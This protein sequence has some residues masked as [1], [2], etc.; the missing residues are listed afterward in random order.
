MIRRIPIPLVAGGISDNAADQGGMDSAE[1]LVVRNAF[2]QHP[3]TVSV[4]RGSANGDAMQ[5]DQGTPADVTSVPFLDYWQDQQV[6]LAVTHST[7]QN[8]H[9][10]HRLNTDATTP[11]RFALPA[12]YD[13]AAPVLITGAGWFNVEY[14]LADI[15]QAKGLVKFNGTTASLISLD[16]GGGAGVLKPKKVFVHRNHLCILGYGD[17]VTEIAPDLFRYSNIG[18]PDVFDAGDFE[19]IGDSD[20]PLTN[21]ISVDEFGLLFK[22]RRIYRLEGAGR[23]S[24]SIVPID[25]NRGC[26]NPRAATVYEGAA[27]FI[28][29]QGFCRTS[30]GGPSELL[31]DQ[32]RVRWGEV[33]FLANSWVAPIPEERLVAFGVHRQPSAGE[34]PDVLYCVDVRTG[35]WSEREYQLGMMHAASIPQTTYQGPSDPPTAAPATVITTTGWTANWTNGDTRDG[36]STRHETLDNDDPG[37]MW[38][39]DAS[40][41][42]PTTTTPITGKLSGRDYQER[43]R[44]ERG[45]LFSQYSA[46]Q[47]VKTL[48]DVPNKAVTGLNDPVNKV[49][50]VIFNDNEFGDVVLER[51]PDVAGS[52]GTY[53]DI[54]TFVL[55]GALAEHFDTTATCSLYYWYRVRATR[56]GWTDSAPSSATRVLACDPN[57]PY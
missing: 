6:I 38:V 37:G 24:W 32:V 45:G 10:L 36:V 22:E 13:V 48:L 5:D 46:D 30:L 20:E 11:T 12:A 23:Q 43:Y 47:Q 27:W 54:Y 26:V 1:A 16:L 33:D 51:A 39:Q 7:I 41:P 31:I 3:T 49:S 50:I 25:R 28:S 4:R 57:G 14:Y 52:P 29:D 19:G 55:P 21:G 17:A 9:Y 40:E 42:V 35:R 2:F 8:K 34:F 53:A 56:T 44:H 18:V 15:A